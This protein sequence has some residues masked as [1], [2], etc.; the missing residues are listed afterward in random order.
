MFATSSFTVNMHF[1]CNKLVDI[2]V[3]TKAKV[4]DSSIMSQTN[5]T[6]KSSVEKGCCDNKSIIKKGEDN[7]QK[8]SFK[9]ENQNL[10]FLHTLVYTYANLFEGLDKNTVPFLNYDPPLIPKDI[11]VLHEVYLI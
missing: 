9:M 10:V 7:L 5:L 4:C 1:C 2:A 8:T 3:L 11:Q 6:K